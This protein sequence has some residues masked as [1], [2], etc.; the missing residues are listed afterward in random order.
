MTSLHL[1]ID[2]SSFI[3]IYRQIEEAIRSQILS[4][5][6]SLYDKI[7]SENELSKNFD[8]SPM[9][10]R[11]AMNGLVKD[12][13]VYRERGKGTFVA[14]PRLDH[15]LTRLV[16]FSEDMEA[17]G[18]K[19]GNKILTF[20]YLPATEEVARIL[21]V[22]MGETILHIKRTRYAN[23]HPVGIHDT[24]LRD[25]Q[26]RRDELEQTSS[27]YKLLKLRG[28]I[29]DRGQDVIEAIL[30]TEEISAL[31]GVR[32]KASILRVTRIT[33]TADRT[34]IEMVIAVYRSDFYR[35][36]IELKR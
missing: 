2:K 31:L 26:I 18:V 22:P 1:I 25:I 11:Q 34:P 5:N 29:I 4:G 20:S 13:Y 27:L 3:P 14:P 30:A 28:V 21:Q 9:T 12:G 19:P 24:Y 7:P 33:Y 17:R 15:P 10:V 35:Y 23:D 16:G 36:R 8:V 32:L 6:M